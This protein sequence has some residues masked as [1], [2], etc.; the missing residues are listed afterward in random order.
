MLEQNF[1]PT[2]VLKSSVVQRPEPLIRAALGKLSSM[3]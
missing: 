1:A 2:L 3:D